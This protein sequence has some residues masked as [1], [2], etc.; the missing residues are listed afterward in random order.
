[1]ERGIKDEILN[2]IK[3]IEKKNS[4]IDKYLSGL[5]FLSRNKTIKDIMSN[6]IENNSI[7]Q[8]IE[9]SKGDYLHLRVNDQANKL[10]DLVESFISKIQDT[11]TKKIIY[12]R[13]HQN[14]KKN[15]NISN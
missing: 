9:K 2:M 12:L 11:P 3:D 5:S 15:R 14:I 10:H 4:E 8:E 7:L 1:M 6:I 13:T